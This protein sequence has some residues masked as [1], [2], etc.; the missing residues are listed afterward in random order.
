M[1]NELQVSLICSG[2]REA[3]N[4]IQTDPQ[5]TNRFEPKVLLNGIMMK[6]T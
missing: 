1:S 4:A 6:N 3:F 2:T 5:L